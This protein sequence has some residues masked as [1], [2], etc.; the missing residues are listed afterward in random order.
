MMT[1]LHSVIDGEL[2][3]QL[4]ELFCLS[5]PGYHDSVEGIIHKY[6]SIARLWVGPYLVVIVTE[7]KYMEVSEVALA[8]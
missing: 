1:L 5:E 6:G 3:L 8:L 7:A 2:W 4:V